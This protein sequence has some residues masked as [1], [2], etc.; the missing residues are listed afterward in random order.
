[1]LSVV[2]IIILSPLA[3]IC[4]ILS[5][6]ILYGA[7]KWIVELILKSVNAIIDTINKESNK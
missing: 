2:L 6:A 4:A 1:M 3:I 7:V 5:V